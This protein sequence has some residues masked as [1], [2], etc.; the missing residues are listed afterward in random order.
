MADLREAWGKPGNKD[1]W[2]PGRYL[3]LTREADE[4]R[5]VDDRTWTDLEFPRIFATLDT[6]ITRIGS[7]Y[8]FRQLRTWADPAEGSKVRGLG[9]ALRRNQLLR[10]KIQRALISVQ[11]DSC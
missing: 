6:T 5:H 9:E 2:L 7:Q 11:S 4:A 8:L 3:E 10:Q 1:P